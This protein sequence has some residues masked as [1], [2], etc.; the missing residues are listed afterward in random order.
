MS[1]TKVRILSVG[2][3]E[4]LLKKIFASFHIHITLEMFASMMIKI[5]SYTTANNTRMNYLFKTLHCLHIVIY[6]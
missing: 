5:L 6:T 4:H 2:W 3:I 1:F